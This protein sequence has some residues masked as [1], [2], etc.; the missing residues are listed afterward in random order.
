[1][2]HQIILCYCAPYFHKG[3]RDFSRYVSISSVPFSWGLWLVG[4][5]SW[6]FFLMSQR[7]ALGNL[8]VVERRVDSIACLRGGAVDDGFL[9]AS[10]LSLEISPTSMLS[11]AL[12]T[13]GVD[14]LRMWWSCASA[15]LTLGSG[16]SGNCN[17]SLSTF[18]PPWDEKRTKKEERE[19]GLRLQGPKWSPS[20]GVYLQA[21]PGSRACSSHAVQHALHKDIVVDIDISLPKCSTV[22]YLSEQD[23][24]R[25][26]ESSITGLSCAGQLCSQR[27]YWQKR[28][29][30]LC[31]LTEIAFGGIFLLIP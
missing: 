9:L 20:E 1:M 31:T 10:V 4:P 24:Q 15:T 5:W 21:S 26:G 13:T 3:G 6:F 8:G 17:T 18:Q 29:I 16:C 27:S 28:E 19:K 12:N 23:L 2:L 7:K 30:F 11:L 14:V 22:S 25:I